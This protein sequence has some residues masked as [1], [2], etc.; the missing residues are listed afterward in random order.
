M[1]FTLASVGRRRRF[2]ASK[3]TFFYTA[4]G[5]Q[6]WA[7]TRRWAP[8]GRRRFPVEE[9]SRAA[10]RI[11]PQVLQNLGKTED[12]SWRCAPIETL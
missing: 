12:N 10:A 11:N 1:P 9:A 5:R 8:V 7:L 2:P 4:T 6:S 3:T